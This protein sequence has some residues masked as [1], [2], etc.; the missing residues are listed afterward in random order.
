MGP[1]AQAKASSRR[2]LPQNISPQTKKVGAPKIK[3]AQHHPPRKVSG[4]GLAFSNEHDPKRQHA[5]PREFGR[6]LP[7]DT[8][9]GAL[10][11][12]VAPGVLALFLLQ[13]ERRVAPAERTKDGAEEERSPRDVDAAADDAHDA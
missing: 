9:L 12:H 6:H 4:P 10:P 3:V 13:D 11:G 5:Q 2:S 8:V 1:D 7:R